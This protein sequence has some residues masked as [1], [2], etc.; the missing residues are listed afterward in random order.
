MKTVSP[1]ANIKMTYV[2]SDWN[3]YIA[4]YH[5]EAHKWVLA[6]VP[7][8]VSVFEDKRLANDRSIIAPYSIVFLVSCRRWIIL[9]ALTLWSLGHILY[10]SCQV[11]KHEGYD[12]IF[13]K[14]HKYASIRLTSLFS[15]RLPKYMVRVVAYSHANQRLR[16]KS[17]EFQFY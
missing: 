17:G 1:T 2:T 13:V 3:K 11:I 5:A 9:K 7:R 12:H 6:D 4:E 14:H 16:V 15:E 10:L 8:Q